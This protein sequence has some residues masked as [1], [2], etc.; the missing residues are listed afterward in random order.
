MTPAPVKPTIPAHLLDQ[1]DIRVGSIEAVNDVPHSEKLVALTVNFGDHK[2]TVLVGMKRERA[3]PREI[4]GKQALF[5]VNLAPRTMAGVVSEGMLFDI[6]YSDGI[7]AVLA[8]PESRAGGDESR[9][10]MVG[11]L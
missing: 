3:D 8:V 2:R 4:E 9:M 1:I 11:W 10:M 7:S 6:G 5:V